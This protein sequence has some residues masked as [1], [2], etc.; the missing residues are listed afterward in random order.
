MNRS[1]Y[2]SNTWIKAEVGEIDQLPEDIEP[3]HTSYRLIGRKVFPCSL[4]EW[5]RSFQDDRTVD[6]DIFDN[7]D[8]SVSTVFLGYN[9]RHLADGPPLLFETMIFGGIHSDRQWRCSCYREA[10]EQHKR[11]C[12]MVRS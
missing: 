1:D 6:R 8:I 7:G 5:S 3:D 12:D 11:A 10:E 2:I 9:H 4:E